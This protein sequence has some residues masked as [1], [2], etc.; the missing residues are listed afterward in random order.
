LGFFAAAAFL[1]F[2]ILTVILSP[3]FARV[4]FGIGWHF[5][6]QFCKSFQGMANIEKFCPMS[7]LGQLCHT[8][9]V[10]RFYYVPRRFEKVRK[11]STVT[12]IAENL[13]CSKAKNN[14]LTKL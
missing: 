2:L 7:N 14:G 6:S 5:F 8:P 13:S 4:S 9:D 12:K 11:L 3:N 10:S 1:P